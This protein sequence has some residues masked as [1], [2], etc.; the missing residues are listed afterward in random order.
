MAPVARTAEARRHIASGE[1][2]PLYLLEG[3]DTQSRHDLAAEFLALVD[4]GLRAFNVETLHPSE[5]TGAAARD[6]TIGAMLSSARTLPMMAPRRLILVHD[7]E[8]LLSPRRGGDDDGPPAPGAGAR[9]KRALTPAEELED[10]FEK[11]E[12]LTTV[13]FTAG[14]LDANRRLVKLLRKR[15]VVVDCGSLES[16]ADAAAWIRKRLDRDELAID[17]RAVALLVDATGLDLGR[18]R[19]ETEKLVLYAAGQPRVTADDVREVVMPQHE[20]GED[21]A[22]GKAIWAGSA[23]EALRE[24]A[25]QLDAGAQPPMVLG[26]IRAA[27]IRLRPEAR[28]AR[29]L[30]AVFRTDLAI[31]SSAGTPRHLIECLVIDLCAKPG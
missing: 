9:K 31:K 25:A 7:A 26:Q 22:L 2:R 15:A 10:Y 11:P 18:V 30:D 14:P 8:R 20:P 24:V 4:E 17:D 1:A 23:A 29:G 16:T 12:P 5:A 19:A 21:F 6:A 3:G 27:A 28:A 13:V